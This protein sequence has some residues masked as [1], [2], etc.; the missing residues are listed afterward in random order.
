MN[1]NSP[2][3]TWKEE[4]DDVNEPD[5]LTP[6]ERDIQDGKYWDD[7]VDEYRDKRALEEQ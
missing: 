3:W 7:R 1:P 5:D 4:P 6:E 2:Y